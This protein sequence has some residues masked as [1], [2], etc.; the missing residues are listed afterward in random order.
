M[1][2]GFLIFLKVASAFTSGVFL[3]EASYLFAQHKRAKALVRVVLS[4][5]WACAV[6]YIPK[7]PLP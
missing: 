1:E 3:A 4:I 2:I 7:Y 6:W 5:V